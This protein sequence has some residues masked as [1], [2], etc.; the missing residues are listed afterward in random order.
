MKAALRNLILT[1]ALSLSCLSAQVLVIPQVADGAG[2]QTTIVLTNTSAYAASGTLRFHLD[3]TGG[4][5]EP[6]SPPFLEGGST[7]GMSL[8][9]GS[10]LFLH[11]PGMAATLSQ[12]WG[13]S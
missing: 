6:W 11:T 7:T 10:T 13:N 4:A 9:G 12:G 2:W 1:I 3:T 8:P 5:T